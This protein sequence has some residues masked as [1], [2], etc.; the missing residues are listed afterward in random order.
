MLKKKKKTIK[1]T[2]NSMK[3]KKKKQYEG[4][5]WVERKRTLARRPPTRLKKET[6]KELILQRGVI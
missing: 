1:I 6:W 3:A 5:K 2:F 4:L